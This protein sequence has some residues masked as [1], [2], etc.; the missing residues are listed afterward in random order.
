MK[1]WISAVLAILVLSVS[2]LAQTETGVVAGTVVDPTGAVVQGA[3]VTATNLATQAKRTVTTNAEGLFSL[4]ALPPGQY[5]VDVTS[6]NFAPYKETLAVTVG[7]RNVISPKLQLTTTA[8]TVEV[9]AGGGAVQVETQTSDLSTVV[10]SQQISNLPTLTRN[11]YDFVATS[12]NVA[13]DQ[14]SGLAGRGANGIS[15]NGQRAASTSILLDGAE[16]VD[17]FTASVG[18]QVPLDSVQEF[19]VT[20]SDW[21]AE[22]GRA[23][24]GVVNVAT[25]SGGNDFHGS[26]YEFNRLSAL[27]TNT[28]D[29]NANGTPK[30]GFTRNQFGYSIGGPILKNKLFFFNSTEW[31]RVRSS[32]TQLAYVPDASFLA[33]TAA[34]T[35][36]YFSTYG[37]LKSGLVQK[38]VLT[39]GDLTG[40][41]VATGPAFSAL[42]ASTKVLDLV[43]FPFNSDAGGGS[44]QNAINSVVRVDFTLSDKTSMF[45]RY[46]IFKDNLFDGYVSSNA[47]QGF[48]TGETDLNQNIAFS[49]THV[50]SPRLLSTTKLNYNRLN[51]LQPLTSLGAIPNMYF[52][53]GGQATINGQTTMLPGYL[54]L[55]TANSIPFGGPQNVT[56]FNEAISFN[57]GAHEFKFGGE[58]IYTQ[59][60]RV[61]G[62]YEEGGEFLAHNSVSSAFDALVTGNNLYRFTAAIDPQNKFPCFRDPLTNGLVQTSSCTIDGPAGSPNFSRS[63][64]YNDASLYFQDNWKF[65]RRLNVTLG[66]RWEYYG[67]QHDKTASNDANLVLGS[68]SNFFQQLSTAYVANGHNL[69]DGRLW[70]PNYHQFGPRL[71]F[72]YDL[73]GDGKTSLRGGYGI[74]YERNFGNVTFNVIQNPPNYAVLNITNGVDVPAGSISITNSNLGPAAQPGAFAFPSPTLRAVDRN[75]KPA[76]AHMWNLSLE[77]SLAKSTVAS[78]EYSGA[79]GVNQYSIS[80]F[81]DFGYGSTFMGVGCEPGQTQATCTNPLQRLNLQYNAINYRTNGG[82]SYHHALNAGVRT[83]N[84]HNTGLDLTANYTWSH[85]I[86]DLSATFGGSDEYNGNTLGFLNPYNP[87]L[88]KGDSDYDVRHRFVVSAV[89]AVPFAKETQGW[90]NQV[91][92]GWEA[93]PIITARTGYPLTIYD[94]T[95]ANYN[96]PRYIPSGAVGRSASTST[97]AS[98]MQGPNVFTYMT[99]P[100][101]LTYLDPSLSESEIPTCGASGCKFPSN[102]TSRNYFRQPGYWNSNL[103]IF[104]N[105]KVTER[106]RM[107]FRTEFYNLFNHSNYYVQTGALNNVSGFG[108]DAYATTLNPGTASQVANINCITTATCTI[109]APTFT[110]AAGAGVPYTIIGKKGNQTVNNFGSLGE[111][112]FI[113]LALRITF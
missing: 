81:N 4:A 6:P 23:S 73:T 60:N 77:R 80:N 7:S 25:K 69:P 39:A 28:Y 13:E 75:I 34:N 106:V 99:V 104:K 1:N 94:C 8:T 107:Q 46:A 105:F 103:G 58:Y 17:L 101:A 72:A 21:A 108:A 98:A 49:M 10:S 3:T 53:T 55:S 64:R 112:R 15:I 51:D 78:L 18:Q 92:D 5:Q 29:N 27:A 70:N 32:A 26:A 33:L 2:A 113:Q 9:I 67:V 102:M 93:A 24:G 38:G 91:L 52:T 40:T 71:G 37:K 68:G 59:D 20:T 84:I 97:S 61:F 43:S 41:G 79:R 57:R 100:A 50:F 31:T 44:P 63:N 90:K 42:P 56:Q 12:G 86:D 76:Y 47:Y 83:S 45:G 65:N 48:D 109:G 96:C 74:S 85:T 16:N 30:P 95:F 36:D 66:L 22:Y 88:D 62:A 110:N 35:Q 87:G 111:R 54:P 14:G 11:P 89:W 19:R 82:D